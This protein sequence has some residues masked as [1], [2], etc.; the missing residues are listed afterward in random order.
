MEQ[1][2]QMLPRNSSWHPEIPGT[3]YWAMDFL[4]P[5]FDTVMAAQ[6]QAAYGRLTP[7]LVI[8]NVTSKV[9][10]GNIHEVVFDM[11]E[12]VFY[13]SFMA[14]ANSS[15]LPVNGYERQFTRLDAA[16][17]FSETEF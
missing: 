14:G 1:P 3:L 4:C 2:S 12:N 6:L 15:G 10:T 11:T 9:Q 7:E 8:Q 16:T 13:L 5:T 17:L